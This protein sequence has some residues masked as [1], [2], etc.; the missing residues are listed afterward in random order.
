[1]IRIRLS[2][3]EYTHPYKGR[4]YWKWR[5][6]AVSKKIMKIKKSGRYEIVGNEIQ[7]YEE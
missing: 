7:L 4:K 6:N 2:K 3:Q 1:M 5:V